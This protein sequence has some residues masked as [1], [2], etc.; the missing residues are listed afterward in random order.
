MEDFVNER[1]ELLLEDQI[2]RVSFNEVFVEEARYIK[3]TCLANDLVKV[4]DFGSWCGILAQEVFDTGLVLENYH[5]VDAV[6][7]Y[8]NRA[9]SLLHNRPI[10]HETVTLLP[11]SYDRPAPEFMLVHPYDTLN[12]SSLYS[13]LFLREYV[14]RSSIQVP[15][16]RSRGV[17]DYIHSNLD[18]FGPDS[19]VKIDLDGVDIE[20]VAEILKAELQPGAIHFE[21]WNNMRPGYAKLAEA[22]A[23][24]G[25]CVPTADLNQHRNYSVGVS[26]NYWWAVGYDVAAGQYNFTYYD[27]DHGTEAVVLDAPL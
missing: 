12:T 11:P 17:V 23:Q 20:F 18:K 2:V 4:V 25:Y 7:Y 8:M 15:L 1:L 10:T 27:Q 22:L 21:V 3:R 13:E 6:P 26:R 24:R 16:A 19:Y 5:L 9:V 14:K